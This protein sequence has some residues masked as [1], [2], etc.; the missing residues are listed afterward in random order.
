MLEFKYETIA[1]GKHIV[2]ELE[3]NIIGSLCV[4]QYVAARQGNSPMIRTEYCELEAIDLVTYRSLQTVIRVGKQ[5]LPIVVQIIPG[6]G[7][8]LMLGN[9]Y[10]DSH[11]ENPDTQRKVTTMKHKKVFFLLRK[12]ERRAQSD[13]KS[14]KA[15]AS[16]YEARK[17]C[18]HVS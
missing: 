18:R 9:I 10:K 15:N 4:P 16:R 3:V 17:F 7:G 5:V 11:M 12:K 13:S 8:P 14:I 2:K 1:G 6:M